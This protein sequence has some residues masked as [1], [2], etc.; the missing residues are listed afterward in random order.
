[1]KAFILAAG[2]GTR[3]GPVTQETPKCLIELKG[4]ALLARQIEQAKAEGIDDFVIAVGA[5][6]EKVRE[7]VKKNYPNI[8]VEFVESD[9]YKTTNYIYTMHLC[10]KLLN[11]NVLLLHGDI[12][13]E[14]GLL[15][16]LL[17][18]RHENCA[19]LQDKQPPPKKDFKGR[20][21]NGLIKEIGVGLLEKNCYFLPPMYKIS[22]KAMQKWLQEIALFVEKG[23]TS[24]Y[25]ENAFNKISNEIELHAIFFKDELGMEID[26][27]EDLKKAEEIMRQRKLK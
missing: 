26:D 20:L 23:E 25:A 14:Q 15:K 24:V 2:L 17:E 4:K 19:L 12:A 1:M 6:A 13:F 5:F 10:R 22:K 8:K 7:F 16:K 21:E 27:M 3:F 18:C 11:D 9:K